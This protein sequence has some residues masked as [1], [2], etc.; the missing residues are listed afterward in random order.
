MS[1]K[2]TQR[3]TQR[4]TRIDQESTFTV[5]TV[6]HD[7]IPFPEEPFEPPPEE[8]DLPPEERRG[9]PCRNV[10]VRLP[11]GTVAGRPDVGRLTVPGPLVGAGRR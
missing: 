9:G 5:S 6:T 1:Q 11:P 10:V 2:P 7:E 3:P 8:D 4:P